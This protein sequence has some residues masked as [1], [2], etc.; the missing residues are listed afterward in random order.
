M[1]TLER[2]NRLLREEFERELEVIKKIFPDDP[3]QVE[4]AERVGPMT[5]NEAMNEAV[6][7]PIRLEAGGIIEMKINHRKT[8]FFE[9][10]EI[11]R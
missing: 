4:V 7:I 1:N 8:P 5:W 11:Y 10:G 9:G 2:L 3:E 6:T